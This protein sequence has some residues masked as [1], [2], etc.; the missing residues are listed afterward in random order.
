MPFRPWLRFI[1]TSSMRLALSRIT[2]AN[3]PH[4][5]SWS[6]VILN[7][8]WS[9]AIRPST[10]SAWLAFLSAVALA[11]TW[12]CGWLWVVPWAWL[13]VARINAPRA[14]RAAMTRAGWARAVGMG[15]DPCGGCGPRDAAPMAGHLAKNEWDRGRVA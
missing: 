9:S 5:G 7:L 6:A 3:S 14:A 13:G 12:R 10:R 8:A 4:F 15:A 1:S 2:W 11:A